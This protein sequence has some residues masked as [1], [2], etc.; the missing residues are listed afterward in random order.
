MSEIDRLEVAVEAEAK[1]A[2]SELNKLIK[3]LEGVSSVLEKINSGGLES[4]GNSVEK[5]TKSVEGVSKIKTADINRLSR[6]ITKISGSDN[7]NLSKLSHSLDSVG[8]S[9]GTMKSSAAGVDS[10]V[11]QIEKLN[12]AQGK[13]LS[14]VDYSSIG[15]DRDFSGNFNELNAEIS[16]TESQLDRLL[17]KEEKFN[18]LGTSDT[19]KQYLSLQYD[20]AAACNWLDTLYS[21]QSAINNQNESSE[22]TYEHHLIPGRVFQSFDE[23]QQALNNLNSSNGLDSVEMDIK[24]LAASA[25]PLQK[26]A[27][28]IDSIGDSFNET[29]QDSNSFSTQMNN[30]ASLISRIP[31]MLRNLPTALRG[32]FASEPVDKSN[33]KIQNLVSSIDRY[34]DAIKSLEGQGK[35]FGDSEYDSAYQKLSRLEAGL[36]K[37]KKQL[38]GTDTA[39]KKSSQASKKLGDSMD[40]SRKQ[41]GGLSNTLTLLKMSLMYS[42]VFK[43]FAGIG[44]AFSEGYQN[45]ALYSSEFNKTASSLM[46]SLTQLKNSWITAFAPIIT[47]VTPVLVKLIG[48]IS[49]AVTYVGQFIASLTGQSTFIRAKAVQEDYAASLDK[50]GKAAD[51]AAKSLLGFDEITLLNKNDSSG[52]D[53][54]T[55]GVAAPADMFEEVKIDSKV[56]D[57]VKKFKELLEPTEKALKN[58]YNNGFKKFKDFTATGAKDFYK[59]FLVPV[60][61]WTLGKGLPKFF[62]TTNE[63][64]KNIDWKKLNSSLANFWDKLAPFTTN[65]GEGLLWFYDEVLNPVS[66]IVI[67]ESVINFIDS[68]A[69]SL[70]LIN[71]AVGKLKSTGVGKVLGEIFSSLLIDKVKDF[72]NWLDKFA[73][74]IESVNELIKKPNFKTYKDAVID[75]ADAIFNSPVGKNPVWKAIINGLKTVDIEGWFNKD[76]KPWFTK[77]RWDGLI[78]SAKLSISQWGDKI[79]TWWGDVKNA[80]K[81]KGSDIVEGFKT[82]YDNVKSEFQ[83]WLQGKPTEI[84][85]WFG[86]IK[87]KFQTKGRHILDGIK[88]GWEN[89]KK[90]FT[91]WIQTKPSDIVTWFGDIKTKFQGKG[92]NIIDGIQSGWDNGWKDFKEWLSD[93]PSKIANAIGSLQSI[94]KDMINDFIKGFKSMSLPK[95]KVNISYETTGLLASAGKALGLD[96]WP[97]LNLGFYES[98]GFPNMG[99]MFVARESGPE[100]VG[101]MG[102]RSNAVANNYQIEAGIEEAAYR[103]FMRALS[104]SDPS[105]NVN[106]TLEGEAKGLFK[107]VKREDDAYKG[108]TGRSAFADA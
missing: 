4:L 71:T 40:K 86:D 101:S 37:Y 26:I 54:A 95:I 83:K 81:K 105:S 38:A 102:G 66:K 10:V 90:D 96:G 107:L 9:M 31:E 49:Q 85:N 48:Y 3:R 12:M 72:S 60:G 8:E 79:S 50:T 92:K 99:Q 87:T 15:A 103:G 2:N 16:K 67:N 74:S 35:Y 51:K 33:S 18:T 34:K 98:G 82:G 76:V 75:A 89:A 104:E 63:I 97:K 65:V 94:G 24:E 32:A 100:L 59:N 19:S 29:S 57:A 42:L 78:E 56:T 22:P 55:P 58:L 46:S 69:N 27:Q 88:D 7:G 47:Y 93:L 52:T 108:R 41:A 17:Q 77:E 61:K 91:A 20:I 23:L 13:G 39:Q 84:L 5:F 6:N 43:A 25:E 30:T 36:S 80:F 14:G 11:K 73:G 1:K 53:T 28:E 106:V 62:D 45:L 21:K 70:E 44:T 64:L 68:I